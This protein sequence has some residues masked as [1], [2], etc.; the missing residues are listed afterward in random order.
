MNISVKR[1]GGFAGLSQGI[2]A[3]DTTKLQPTKAGQIE[4]MVQN[5][6]FFELPVRVAG[7]TVGADF[8]QYD[9]TVT[10]AGQQHTVSFLDD[11]SAGTAPLRKLVD[12]LTS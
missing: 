5:L 1:S 8:F 7:E 11:G 9:V 10:S 3:V 12:L 4:Q 2:A 6:G